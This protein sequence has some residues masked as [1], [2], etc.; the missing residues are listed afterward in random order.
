M[1]IYEF[2]PIK[3]LIQGAYWLVTSLSDLLE[4]LAGAQSAALAIVALTLAVRLLL[5]PVGRSQAKAA[6][7][8]QRLAPQLA[9]LKRRYKNPEVLQRKTM[10][11]YRNEK[12]SP[13]AGC[14]PVLAQMPVLMAVYGLFIL[15]TINGGPNAL[16][17]HTLFGVPLD[18]QLLGALTGATLTLPHAL[19][20]LGI[21]AI[22]FAVT[23]ASRKL[24][25]PAADAAQPQPTKPA[26]GVPELPDMS[27]IARAMSFVPFVTV[28]VAAFVP[29]A[30]ALY[31]ATTTAWTLCERLVLG[32]I[33]GTLPHARSAAAA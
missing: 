11:L 14:L 2:G 29:L 26:A 16:L 13:F 25:T 17:S 5:V 12:A 32:K 9:E 6:A 28:I 30:A 19:V 1:N 10:E 23:L 3:L 4:P 18:A 8:R 27:G 7:D 24:L 15:P 31:L 20:G 22:V 33:Y 21:M